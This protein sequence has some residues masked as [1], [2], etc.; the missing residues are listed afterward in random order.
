M[1][2]ITSE[3]NGDLIACISGDID[4]HSAPAIRTEIDQTLYGAKWKR[5]VLDLSGTDFMDSSG[6]GLILGRKQKTEEM[7]AGFVVLNPSEQIL[8]ILNYRNYGEGSILEF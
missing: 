3:K 5:L 7:G 4:H 6:L 1:K 2:L 8:K